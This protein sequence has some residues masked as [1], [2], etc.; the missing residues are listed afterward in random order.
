MDITPFAFLKDSSAPLQK[1]LSGLK[2]AGK[3]VIS[4]VA[5]TASLDE[6]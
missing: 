3:Q 4:W 5:T 1:T 2:K 6:K